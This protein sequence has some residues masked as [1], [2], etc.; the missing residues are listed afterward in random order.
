MNLLQ[1]YEILA[2]VHGLLVLD[3]EPGDRAVL[4]RLDLDGAK[5]TTSA[6]NPGQCSLM[7]SLD[8]GERGDC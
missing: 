7:G 1:L 2:R 8:T 6:G 4:F 5:N 3:E